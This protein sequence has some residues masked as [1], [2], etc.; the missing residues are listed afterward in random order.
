MRIEERVEAIALFLAQQ[1][2][3]CHGLG[4]YVAAWGRKGEPIQQACYRCADLRAPRDA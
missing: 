2:P 4:V 3:I 1:C